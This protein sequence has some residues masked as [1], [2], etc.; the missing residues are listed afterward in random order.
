MEL[1][2]AMKLVSD[3]VCSQIP[4]AVLSTSSGN[5]RVTVR[6]SPQKHFHLND[7]KAKLEQILQKV[8]PLLIDLCLT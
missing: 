4:T 5:S 7:T 1:H 8:C 6:L 3:A 2:Q